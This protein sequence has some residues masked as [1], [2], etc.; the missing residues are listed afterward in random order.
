MEPLTPAD[1]KRWDP[2]A[3]HGV[4]QTAGQRADTLQRLRDSLQQVHNS[5]SDWHGEAGDAFRADLGKTPCCS[6]IPGN[7]SSSWNRIASA[8]AGYLSVLRP[9][10]MNDAGCG[11]NVRTPTSCTG[12]FRAAVTTTRFK[13]R[14]MSSTEPWRACR[15]RPE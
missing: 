15:S 4:F 11:W 9:E 5:L 13:P 14:L 8:A 6:S 7:C 1:V 3:I 12:S 10:R 2:D